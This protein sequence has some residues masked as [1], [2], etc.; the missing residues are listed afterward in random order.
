MN[1]TVSD[2]KSILFWGE[3]HSLK[4]LFF[5]VL[6]FLAIGIVLLK[7]TNSLAY[8]GYAVNDDVEIQ[9]LLSGARGTGTGFCVQ[10]NILLG[11]LIAFL[12]NL[13]PALNWYGI[14]M[15][16]MLILSTAFISAALAHRLGGKAG[17]AI[18]FAVYPLLYLVILLNFTYTLVSFAVL[19]SAFVNL[20]YAF[21]VPD[22]KLKRFLWISAAVLCVIAVMIRPNALIS[23]A[24]IGI[25]YALLLAVR[26]KKDALMSVILV[27]CMLLVSLGLSAVSNSVYR[28]TQVWNNFS[29]FHNIRTALQDRAYPE[30]EQNQE[31]YEKYGWSKN[32]YGLFYSSNIPDDPDFSNQNLADINAAD[33]TPRYNFDIGQLF[34]SIY[35]FLLVHST[36]LFIALLL[37]FC[38]ALATS[39]RKLLSIAVFVFPFVM[40]A[41][42]F[43][44]QRA[45]FRVIFPHYII[46]LLLLLCFIDTQVLKE[47]LL[48]LGTKKLKVYQ[49]TA[50]ILILASTVY[51]VYDSLSYRVELT[52]QRSAP[53][54]VERLDMQRLLFDY[55]QNYTE[56]YFVYAME[57]I[58]YDFNDDVSIFEV[59]PQGYYS[60][61]FPLGGWSVRSGA[62]TEFKAL[63]G[64]SDLPRDLIDNDSVYFLAES[65]LQ[66]YTDY[67]YE[68][69]GI[70][71]WYKAC[72][73]VYGIKIM[74]V[75]TAPSVE[76][77]GQIYS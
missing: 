38:F 10:L 65:K 28:S 43:I 9:N 31:N 25:L 67:F 60:N 1:H 8:I 24:V 4:R 64:V 53:D 13:L 70:P 34:Y 37:A 5:Y 32:D 68:T 21:Y 19:A 75:Q 57:P 69:Y 52:K 62:Y 51:P 36:A 42:F 77:M 23:A 6:I 48:K 14:F 47:K 55:F 17:F 76:Q 61:S 39:R 2:R 73:F 63:A 12:Y 72:G 66:E 35:D 7:I 74:Q 18:G 11:T 30:Y 45:L 33:T 71:V 22:K 27:A 20:A 41:G 46:S 26:Y 3:K 15:A 56:A 54:L 58:F 44:I 59:K 50:F 49:L 40:Q 29:E 16:G